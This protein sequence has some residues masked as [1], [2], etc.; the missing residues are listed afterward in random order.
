MKI[1]GGLRLHD[2]RAKPLISLLKGWVYA[3]E[4]YAQTMK[5]DDAAYYYNERA[6][7]S[8]LASGAWVSNGIALEEYRNSKGRGNE[9][10][11]GRAD[12]YVSYRSWDAE[13]EAKQK[14]M[15]AAIAD[16]KFRSVVRAA[17]RSAVSDATKDYAAQAQ[18]GCVFFV[19]RFC[20]SRPRFRNYKSASEEY[21][22]VEI[23]RY[24]KL[25]FVDMWAWC[26][27]VEA[28]ELTVE[29]ENSC[30][31]GVILGLKAARWWKQ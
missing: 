2:S 12:L 10:K 28:R 15:N 9:R 21:I 3:I 23:K 20:L 26:F 6:S 31:P 29:S 16:V 24:T 13:F 27:P 7:L 8:V 17:I 30:Y 4:R 22:S 18:F 11:I 5:G 14:W 25:S 1:N 19:P